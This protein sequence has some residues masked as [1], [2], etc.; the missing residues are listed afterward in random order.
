MSLIDEAYQYLCATPS[1]I[2]EHLPT[3][4]KYAEQC[5]SVLE[6]GTRYIVSTYSMLAAR[7]KKMVSVDL[8]DPSVYGGN[9]NAVLIA[10]QQEG[11]D[12]KFIQGNDLE[13]EIEDNFDLLFVDTDHNY[14]QLTSELNK[15]S[16]KINKFIAM[17]DT[18][19]FAEPCIY[20]GQEYGGM[21]RAVFD[22]INNHPE[23]KIK[24]VFTNNNGLTVLERVA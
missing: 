21:K 10:C 18:E 11:I 22:F 15:Y 12:Y 6:L 4:K 24:E 20:Q 8:Y 2:N 13:I 17:H 19:L 16:P 3:L 5:E 1:D 23:W 7:P 14:R 9:L